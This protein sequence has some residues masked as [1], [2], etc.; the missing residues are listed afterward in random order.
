MAATIA[1]GAAHL[2]IYHF[3]IDG[4]AFVELHD[5]QSLELGPGD[6]VVFP[7]G[8]S[9]QMSSGKGTAQ[10]F[11][12]YGISAKIKARDLSPM[13]AGGGRRHVAVRMRVHDLRSLT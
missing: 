4:G 1:P 6:V 10:P 13:H 7:H 3:V 11:P 2:V 5:G 12:N 9:H 8:H